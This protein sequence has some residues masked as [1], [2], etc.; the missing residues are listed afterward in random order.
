M[1]LAVTFIIFLSVSDCQQSFKWSLQGSINEKPLEAAGIGFGAGIRQ[2]Q[3][4]KV[5]KE[6]SGCSNL[7]WVLAW[8][9][10]AGVFSRV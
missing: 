7:A 4:G 3:R 5:G 1:F 6:L 8:E 9:G 2:H 10:H